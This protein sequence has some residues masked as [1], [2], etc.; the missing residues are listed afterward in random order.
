MEGG[1]WEVLFS[2]PFIRLVMYFF[3]VCHLGILTCWLATQG[4]LGCGMFV[5]PPWPNEG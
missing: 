2:I 4:D 5:V 3:W 1:A